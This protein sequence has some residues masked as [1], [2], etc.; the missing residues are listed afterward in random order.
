MK[1]RKSNENSVLEAVRGLLQSEANRVCEL[2]MLPFSLDVGDIRSEEGYFKAAVS[3]RHSASTKPP[4]VNLELVRSLL[5]TIE[6]NVEE[7]YQGLRLNLNPLVK[8]RVSSKTRR[9][10]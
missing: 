6:Q 8:K 9:A 4:E 1:T 7:T 5:A 3:V 2:Y 10:G